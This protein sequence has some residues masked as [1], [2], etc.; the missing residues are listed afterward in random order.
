MKKNY[1]SKG[2]AIGFIILLF[3]AGV[4]PIISGMSINQNISVTLTLRPNA[5]GVYNQ[6]CHDDGSSG[7]SN[8]YKEV[9]ETLADGDSSYVYNC[10]SYMPDDQ[11][12]IEDTSPK[13]PINYVKVYV[14]GKGSGEV[15][16]TVYI[17]STLHRGS[18]LGLSSDWQAV[19]YTWSKNPATGTVWYWS[20]INNLQ[21]GMRSKN[22]ASITQVYAEVNYIDEDP[23][24]YEPPAVNTNNAIPISDTKVML[25]GNLIDL[26]DTTSCE[27]WFEYG[28]TTSYGSYTDHETKTSIGSFSQNLTGLLKDKTYHFRAVAKNSVGTTYGVDKTFYFDIPDSGGENKYKL[29]VQYYKVWIFKIPKRLDHHVWVNDYYTDLLVEYCPS[30]INMIA[31]VIGSIICPGI[32]SAI[33][34]QIAQYIVTE[35]TCGAIEDAN[36]GN[37]VKFTFYQNP[38]TTTIYWGKVEPQ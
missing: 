7:D 27:V 13:G 21:I 36:Q 3:G 18:R 32:G 1:K 25:T 38:Y 37:G 9:D 17:G 8:N 26:G 5:P 23:H 12:N 19:S 15:E 11:Y 6:H 10:V 16:P 30:L 20:D 2:L 31:F 29:I 34:F 4:V 22:S 35:I 28:L 33:A 24:P 14:V